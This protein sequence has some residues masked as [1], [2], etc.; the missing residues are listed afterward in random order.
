MSFGTG[1]HAT[2]KTVLEC[3]QLAKARFDKA[4]VLDMGTG[5]EFRYCL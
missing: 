4:S 1:H 3:M 2:T 5:R